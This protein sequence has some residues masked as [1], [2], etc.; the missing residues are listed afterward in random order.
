MPEPL[1]NTYLRQIQ[2]RVIAAP[3]GPWE[4]QPNDYGLPDQVGPIAYLQ[5]WADSQLVPTVEF[6]GHARADVPALLGEVAR[7]QTVIRD[8][9]HRI[10]QLEHAQNGGAR[11]DR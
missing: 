3:K 8:L 10:R 2:D 5:T 1:T 11:H 7:Q 6:I 4:V 9:E